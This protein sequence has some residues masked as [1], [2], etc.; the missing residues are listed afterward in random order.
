MSDSLLTIRGLESGYGDVQVLW[1]LNME[2]HEGEITA[3]IGSNGAG[4][5]TLMRTISGLVRAQRGEISFL[6]KSLAG[7][8]PEEVLNA[9]IAHVPEGRRLFKGL[10]VRDNLLLGAYTRN[11]SAA[12]IQKDLEEI[13][14]VFPRLRERFSQDASTL[15]GG[16]QQMCAIGRGLMS[17]PRLLI[18][19]ELSLGLAPK[20]TEQLVDALHQFNAKGLTILLVE[21]DVFTALDMAKRAYVI[22][23]GRVMLSGLSPELH[24]NPMIRQAYLGM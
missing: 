11:A 21:Q 22:E 13:Y 20:A 12:D 16:E 24:D 15:S 2:V 8:T 6:G 19:D 3:V 7:A 17:K 18:I 10:S 23:N 1:G 5:S 14:A 4:K 9:G